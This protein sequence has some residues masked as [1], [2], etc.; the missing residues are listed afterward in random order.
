MATEKWFSKQIN[1]DVFYKDIMEVLGQFSGPFSIG[2]LF[3][4]K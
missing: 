1:P 4:T 3:V 2:E